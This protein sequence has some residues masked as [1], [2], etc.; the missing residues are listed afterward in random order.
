MREHQPRH[1]GIA[2]KGRLT[3]GSDGDVVALRA[4]T[5]EPMFVAA[6][7]QLVMREGCVSKSPTFLEESN[8]TVILNG[9]QN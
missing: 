3:S 5:L 6:R 7:G 8:R 4:G 2:R 1:G 9:H